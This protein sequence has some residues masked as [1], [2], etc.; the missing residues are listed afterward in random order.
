MNF[1]VYLDDE[2]EQKLNAIAQVEKVSRNSLIKEAVEL[3]IEK[4]EAREWGKEVLDWQGCPEF[5]QSDNQ[6]L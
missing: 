6:I 5:E 2:L 3:L 1:S 4:R